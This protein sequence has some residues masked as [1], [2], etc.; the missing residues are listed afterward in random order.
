MEPQAQ[1]EIRAGTSGTRERTGKNQE[2]VGLGE[3]GNSRR[4]NEEIEKLLK[5]VDNHMDNKNL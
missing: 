1:E 5:E 4:S 3:M 2:E